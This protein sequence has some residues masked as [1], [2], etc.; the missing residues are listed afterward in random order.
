MILFAELVL[1]IG[2]IVAAQWLGPVHIPRW[3]ALASAATAAVVALM[4]FLLCLATT[5]GDPVAGPDGVRHFDS[6]RIVVSLLSFVAIPIAI[7]HLAVSLWRP[8]KAKEPLSTWRRRLAKAVFVGRLLFV[9]SPFLV[10]L[11]AIDVRDENI[12]TDFVV[13]LMVGC[14]ALFSVAI[15]WLAIAN[16]RSDRD[17]HPMSEGLA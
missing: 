4:A 11:T 8:W 7:W 6:R 10:F 12:G 3:L 5:L 17:P 15:A 14:P 16:W 9:A 1:F 13:V 2:G